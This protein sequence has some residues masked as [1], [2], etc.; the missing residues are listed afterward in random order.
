MLENNEDILNAE[1]PE[2]DK[3]RILQV[4]KWCSPYIG[5]IER[6]VEDISD[7]VKLNFW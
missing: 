2:E 6:V 1:C 7:G 4:A 5:G 3:I